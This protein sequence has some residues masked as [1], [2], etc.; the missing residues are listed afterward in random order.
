LY[1]AVY[2]ESKRRQLTHWYAVM[3][4]GLIILLNRFGFKFHP[5]GDPVDY[6][7]IRTPYLGEIQKIEEEVEAQKPEIYGEFTRGL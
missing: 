1:K 4:K 3:T 2:H 6:H 5:I 7:G